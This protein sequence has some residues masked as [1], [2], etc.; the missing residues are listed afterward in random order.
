MQADINYEHNDDEADEHNTHDHTTLSDNAPFGDVL[1]PK[2][3][4]HTRTYF[5]NLNGLQ[6]DSHGGKWNQTCEALNASQIDIA[7]FAELNQDTQQHSVYT[8]LQKVCS[9]HFNHHHLTLSTTPIKAI[10]TYKPGGTALLTVDNTNARI[11][12]SGRDKL[13][14]WAFSTYATKNN[15]RLLIVSAYQVCEDSS[16]G[17]FTAASQQRSL[18]HMTSIANGSQERQCPRTAF[19][20]D[21]QHFIQEHQKVGSDILLIG[22]FNEELGDPSSGM[23]HLTNE[24]DLRDV[25]ASRHST[26]QSPSTYIRGQRR[27]DY[28]LAS[29]RVL[30]SI[31]SCG[32]DPFNYRIQSDHRGFFIDFNTLQLFG[33][34]T[35]ALAPLSRRDF[36]ASKPSNVVTYC[37]AKTDE[38]KKHDFAKRITKLLALTTPDHHLAESLDRDMTRAG[39]IAAKVCQANRQSPWSPSFAHAWSQLYF[40]KTI[41]SMRRNKI[42]MHST[43]SNL[44]RTYNIDTPIPFT[45]SALNEK[46]KETQT[47]LRQV[48]AA[49]KQKRQDHLDQRIRLY[50]SLNAIGKKKAVTRLK[51]AEATRQIFQKLQHLRSDCNKG[52]TSLQVPLNPDDNP[53]SCTQWRT[54]DL[55]SEIEASLCARNQLH[56]GQAEGTPLTTAAMKELFGYNGDGYAADLVL[57]GDFQQADLD[58]YST[59]F[60]HHMQSVTPLNT[61]K[62]EIDRGV[63]C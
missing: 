38:L 20:Q 33:T 25:F 59:L 44:R 45:L 26:S 47:L 37:K 29:P 41:L 36:Q 12:T 57:Q 21:L 7:G 56:F 22:D 46:L 58:Q 62:L 3:P 53:A 14:R 16:Q 9:K 5:I 13:G 61:C 27:L 34:S 50:D 52:V 11:R 54:V 49:A 8:T 6:F 15:G 24:C 31:Q 4:D 23:S 32:Y 43:I 42:D 1:A 17:T 2:S 28:A 18:L 35:T 55:P 30:E 39:L 19:R 51:K 10:T 63:P 60:L 40:F 48:R